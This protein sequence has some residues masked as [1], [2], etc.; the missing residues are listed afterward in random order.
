MSIRLQINGRQINESERM[1]VEKNCTYRNTNCEMSNK[2]AYPIGRNRTEIKHARNRTEI[3][4]H[5]K[6]GEVNLVDSFG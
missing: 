6:N 2:F 5:R 3:K 1:R 4:K